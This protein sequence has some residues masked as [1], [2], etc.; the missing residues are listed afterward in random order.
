MTDIEYTA[1]RDTLK[2]LHKDLL[3]YLISDMMFY[4]KI[5]ITDI[6]RI[7]IERLKFEM[8]EKDK[9]IHEADNCIFN[10]LAYDQMNQVDS[11][12]VILEKVRWRYKYAD[13][14]KEALCEMF[15]YDPEKDDML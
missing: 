11:A 14:N 2:N 6:N 9:I 8:A 10:S 3:C 1:L 15:N 12:N 4:D 7:Y 13:T 5:D